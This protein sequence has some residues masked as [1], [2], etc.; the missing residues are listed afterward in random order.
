MA[1]REQAHVGV[2]DALRAEWAE[3]PFLQGAQQF[4][5]HLDAHVPDLVEKQGP[6]I[7]LL[8]EPLLGAVRPR[9]GAPGMAEELGLKQ[10]VG[11]GRAVLAHEGALLA[12]S[13]VVDGARDE[14]LAGPALALDQHRHLGLDDPVE[15]LEDLAHP[16]ARA[17]HRGVVKATSLAPELRAHDRELRVAIPHL[18]PQLVVER[19]DLP[20]RMLQALVVLS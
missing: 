5:L 9:E 15:L 2:H 1:G 13:V 19:L 3:L 12:R 20:A 4:L 16:V 17:H 8:E 14:L 18:A 10:G 6:A 11:Q 7:G